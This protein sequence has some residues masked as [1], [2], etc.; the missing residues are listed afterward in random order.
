MTNIAC[1]L[2]YSVEADVSLTFA[3]NWRTD[4]SNWIDPPARFQLDGPFASGS[5]GATL[6]PGQEPLRWRLRDVRHE[7]GFVIDL[8]LDR[9]TVSCEW[10]F[11]RVSNHRTRLTQRIVLWGDNAP[12]YVDQ[13]RAGFGSNLADGMKKIAETMTTAAR[14]TER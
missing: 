2:E 1:Q 3:W 7:A 6:L 14:S 10:S 4:V 13:V 12:V 11:D 8:P 9:A 5:S